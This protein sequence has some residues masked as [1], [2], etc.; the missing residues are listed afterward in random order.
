MLKSLT[1][2]DLLA[3]LRR[4][5]A[6]TERG[7]GGAFTID[8]ESLRSI[9]SAADGDARRSLNLLELAADLA[10]DGVISTEIV[11]E[12]ASGSRRR[13][14]KQGEYF[15][16]QISAL[17]K[18]VRGSSPDGALY[19]LT[20]MLD[21]GCDPVYIARRIVRMAS[22]DIG[23]ADPRS[24]QLALDAWEAYERLGAAEGELALAQA[25]IYLACAPKS[26]AVYT[27]HNEARE[28]ARTAGSLEVPMHLRN[29]PTRLAKA[30][31]HGHRYRYAHDEPDGYAA[32]EVYLP[33]PLQQRCYYRPVNRGLEI[34]IREKLD[35]LRQQDIE[36]GRED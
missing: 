2:D 12:V 1:E 28:D 31:G 3:V 26:N 34:R 13:F 6:D 15:Y 33:H 14:D 22:E 5:L 23:N 11:A 10:T 4:A 19:W 27:A 30:L 16:D 36:A 32:G 8:D 25:V 35:R 17:H 9:A 29:A 21:G 7:L 20:R 18:S 24:L